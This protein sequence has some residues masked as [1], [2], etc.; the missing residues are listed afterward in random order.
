MATR[1]GVS[2]ERQVSRLAAMLPLRTAERTPTSRRPV[3]LTA[4]LADIHA[5]LQAL[6]ACLDHARNRGAQRFVFLG[7]LV[8]Y[9]ADARGVLEVVERYAAGGALVLKGNHDEAVETSAAYFND[10][11][12]AALQWARDTLT[13][14]QKCFL[15]ALPLVVRQGEAC[16]AH[17]SAASPERWDYIDSPAAAKRCADA[18]DACYT[19][20]GHVHDQVLYFQ[21]GRARMGEFRPFPGTAIPVPGHRRWVGIVGSVGQPRD[22]N[23]A[24]AYTLFDPARHEVTFFRVPYDAAAAAE[25]IRACGLPAALA[26]RVELGI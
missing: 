20:C 12:R 8:G 7:D 17:A 1:R 6:N 13:T 18:A 15:A 2:R 21:S 16:Y 9:G 22:R 24:A 10:A 14:E 5:N 25:R 11:S 3:V 23:P 4:L 26:Y 19:F